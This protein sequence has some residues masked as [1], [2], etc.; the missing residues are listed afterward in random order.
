MGIIKKV[1]KSKQLAI[2]RVDNIGKIKPHSNL[3]QFLTEYKN[4]NFV[5][6]QLVAMFDITGSM[7]GHFNLVRTKLTEVFQALNE[8]LSAAQ[9]AVFAFRNHGDEEKFSQIYYTSPLTSDINEIKRIISG[10]EKGGGGPDAL[11]CMEECFHAANELPW[12]EEA[13]K[14]IVV[15]GDE[16]PHGVVDDMSKC[17]NR[18]NY[19]VEIEKFIEKGIAVYSVFCGHEMK[20]R[21]FYKSLAGQTGGKFIEIDEIDMLVDL[22]IGISMKQSGSFKKYYEKMEEKG[23]M[24]EARRKVIALLE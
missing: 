13:P 14:A 5:E 20:I 19:K 10:I 7:Y 11:S 15:V 4:S 21:N 1:F 6:L 18:I 2:P 16:P 22:L 17:P 9:F 23:L 8:E 12:L 24:T 3:D